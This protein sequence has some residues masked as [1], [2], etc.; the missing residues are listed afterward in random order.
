MKIYSVVL[1]CAAL[2][3]LQLSAE[4]TSV[5]P[6]ANG[7]SQDYV[8]GDDCTHSDRE[9]P[10]CPDQVKGSGLCEDVY[11]EVSH[12]EGNNKDWA[13]GEEDPDLCEGD[14]CDGT[15]TYHDILS[16]ELGDCTKV[17]VSKEPEL[18]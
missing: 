7:I 14:D 1:V 2:A 16:G 10:T 12:F 9:L 6:F 5:V 17:I 18:F 4:F 13:M 3:C 11:F 8:G 15:E